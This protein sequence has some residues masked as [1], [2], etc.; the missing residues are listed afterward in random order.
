MDARSWLGLEPTHNPHRWFLPVAPGI[1]TGHGFL[2]G[3]SGL[4]AAI[5]AMEGTSE[6]PVVWATAQ[7]LSFAKTGTVVD[8]DVTLAVHGRQTTQ[9]RAV[10]HVGGTEIITVNAALGRRSYPAEHQFPE[11][12]AVQPPEGCPVREQWSSDRPDAIHSRLEQRWALPPEAS[13]PAVLAPGRVAVWSRMP[14]LLEP[15]AASFAVLGDYVPMGV[16]FVLGG[17]VGSTSLDNTLRVMQPVSSDWYLLDI[18][19]DGIRNGFGHG[20]IHIWS[21]DGVLCAIGSQSCIVRR[22]D[23]DD[24]RPPRRLADAPD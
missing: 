20:V 9:A 13:E 18:G 15:S 2:F 24:R 19:V 21:Q 22:R 3:G 7:Y 5:A 12:P 4:G 16:G 1:S 6:R 17:Q 14:E 10:G 8:I 23:P 11:P